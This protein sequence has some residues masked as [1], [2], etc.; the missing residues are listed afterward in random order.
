VKNSPDFY[1]EA[2]FLTIA[3][4]LLKL[5]KED[6]VDRIIFLSA[7]DKRKFPNGD[8]RKFRMIHD[9][10]GGLT[11]KSRGTICS[12]CEVPFSND[13]P[14]ICKDVAKVTKE[15]MDKIIS[16]SVLANE[17]KDSIIAK[18]EKQHLKLIT[19]APYYPAIE[20]H[21]EVVLVKNE[22]GEWKKR[23]RDI[24]CVSNI[25]SVAA[26]LIMQIR[27]QINEDKLAELEKQRF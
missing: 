4:D 13:N 2:P 19:I 9:T 6:K 12:F 24:F 8:E 18:L 25:M 7:Y 27:I 17:S 22:N 10:F 21:P 11:L 15:L 20:H 3:E 23:T 1:Q 16:D 14:N 5:I 26:T